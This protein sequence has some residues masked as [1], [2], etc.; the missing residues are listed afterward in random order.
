MT[1]RQSSPQLES[2]ERDSP[3]AEEKFMPRDSILWR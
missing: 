2:R 1:L 3:P